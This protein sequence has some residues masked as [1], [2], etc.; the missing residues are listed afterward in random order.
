MYRDRGSFGR[1]LCLVQYFSRVLAFL[2]GVSVTLLAVF[3]FSGCGGQEPAPASDNREQP[4]VTRVDGLSDEQS[5]EVAEAGYPDHFFISI[6]PHSGDRIERWSYFSSGRVLEF[7]NGRLSGEEPLEDGAA[8][9]PPTDLRPQDFDALMTAAEAAALLGEP[10]L[11]REVEDS[12]MPENT[13]LVY[14]NVILL[15]RDDKLIGVETQVSP[16]GLPMP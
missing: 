7:D 15:F 10:L 12:L 3:S 9:C 5:R 8:A 4:A 13:I 1:S 14:G 16:P 2:V 6:D 11:T